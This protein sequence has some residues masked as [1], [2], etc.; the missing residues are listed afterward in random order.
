M[1]TDRIHPEKKLFLNI[2][3]YTDFGFSRSSSFRGYLVTILLTFM[4]KC[5]EAREKAVVIS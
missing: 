3:I 4:S 2:I 5:N 1:T